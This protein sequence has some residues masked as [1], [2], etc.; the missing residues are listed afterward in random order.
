MKN[1]TKNKEPSSPTSDLSFYWFLE[2]NKI[3]YDLTKYAFDDIMESYE[4]FSPGFE[5]G[6][7]EKSFAICNKQC[8]SNFKTSR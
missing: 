4:E 2:E 8:G 6:W 7:K 1:I 3:K 5:K